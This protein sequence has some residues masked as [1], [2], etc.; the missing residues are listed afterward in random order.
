M[1]DSPLRYRYNLLEKLKKIIITI[2]DKI[3]YDQLQYD[4]INRFWLE[5]ERGNYHRPPP[6]PLPREKIKNVK[7]RQ[8]AGLPGLLTE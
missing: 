8:V 1:P 4:I 3:R 7:I 6:P 2:K 5:L